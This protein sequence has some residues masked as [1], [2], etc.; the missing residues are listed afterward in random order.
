MHTAK[1]MNTPMMST[2]KFSASESESFENLKLYKSMVGVLQYPTI[3]CPDLSYAINRV[4]QFMHH[5]TILHWKAV[6]RILRYLKNTVDKGLVF[7]KST[8]FR[9]LGFADA[10]WGGDVD[11]RKSISGYYVFMGCNLNVW[12]SNKQSKVSRS[13]TEAEY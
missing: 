10:D 12:K 5:P 6:K 4:S 11:D 2:L 1:H 9:L 8:D 7:N 3:T 13:S